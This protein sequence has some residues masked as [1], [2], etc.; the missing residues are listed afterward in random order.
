M[1]PILFILVLLTSGM[2][3][4]AQE[5]HKLNFDIDT[6]FGLR[7]AFNSK[8]EAKDPYAVGASFGYEYDINLL[9][10]IEGGVRGGVF[11]QKLNNNGY[12]IMGEN[13][14]P[15]DNSTT[16]YKGTYWAPYI[17]PKIYLPF[18]YDDNKDRARFIFIENRF[19]YTRANLYTN[20]AGGN[21]HKYM[22]QYEIR[23]GV[24]LP[25]NQKWAFSCWLGYNSF[26]FSKIK[27][28]AFYFKNS[29]PFQIGIGFN[30][31]IKE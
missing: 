10:G 13:G 19:S 31:I 3:L 20:L 22:L 14:M 15:L 25:L 28:G 12:V 16:L 26:N 1:K 30:Y 11:R 24:H 18:G 27:P 9:F 8:G 17:A 21:M 5:G 29:T 6:S 4:I 7:Y 2:S 23:G